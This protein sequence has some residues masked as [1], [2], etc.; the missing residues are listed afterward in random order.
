MVHSAPV[1]SLDFSLD[2]RLLASGDQTGIIKVWKVNDGKCLRQISIE[3]S[4]NL[5]SVTTVKLSPANSKVFASCLDKTVKVFGLKSGSMLRE[6]AGGHESYIQGFEFLQVSKTQDG[7]N[8]VITDDL[9]IT[10]SFD[11]KVVLW[12]IGPNAK[13]LP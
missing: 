2:N 11:G 12:A 3:L 1:L 7:K 9:V 5:A 10:Y 13:L 6:L 4:Q 8:M